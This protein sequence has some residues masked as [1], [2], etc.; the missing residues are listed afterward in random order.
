M[1][2]C[3]LMMTSIVNMLA[4]ISVISYVIV[5]MLEQISLFYLD[6]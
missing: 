6:V 5:N 1:L 2:L 4:H 3:L